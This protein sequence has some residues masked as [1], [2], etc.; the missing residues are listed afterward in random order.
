MQHDFKV[1][2][3]WFWYMTRFQTQF[4]KKK[5]RM[6]ERLP[7]LCPTTK[8]KLRGLSPLTNYTDRRLS[9]KLLPTFADR[10]CHVVSVTV[11]YGRILG[12]LDWS[13]YIFLQADP[14]PD[15]LFLKKSGSAENP[16]LWITRPQRW[17]RYALQTM[18]FVS[19]AITMKENCKQPSQ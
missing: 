9:A 3:I 18:K 17:S 2:I 7:S 15:P 6:L 8:N 1:M 10:G 14:V 4:S 12:F 13:R 11:H 5:K 16:D 19:P